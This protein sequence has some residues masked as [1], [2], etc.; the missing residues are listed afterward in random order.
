MLN[1]EIARIFRR[2]ADLLELRGENPFKIRSYRT[3]A[4]TI[5]D[6][7]E[8]LAGLLE[9]GDVGAL[10][11]LP[12]IGEAISKKIADLLRTGSFKLW[13]EVRRELP[14]SVL[15]L[16]EVDG[17]GLKTLHVL[18]HQFH[19]TNLQDFARF[20]EGGGLDSVPGMGEKLQQ[21]IRASLR[22][23]HHERQGL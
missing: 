3:A 9:K 22:E 21:R 13:D 8:P 6:T 12:G 18:Y 10:R 7:A 1:S 15:D 23:I 5:E 14:E 19:L 20:V 11:E 4:D 2:L 17:I 16:L